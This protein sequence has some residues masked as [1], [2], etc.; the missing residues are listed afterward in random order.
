MLAS[1]RH[2]LA[3]LFVFSGRETRR[4]FWPYA[5]TVFVG[6]MIVNILLV[7]PVM[8]AAMRRTF[9]YLQQHPEGFPK[10]GPGQQPAFPPELMPDMAP[11]MG[12]MAI[13]GLLVLLLLAAAVV[14]RLHDRD[15]TGWWAALPVPFQVAGVFAAPAAYQAMVHPAA[16]PSALLVASQL[17][18]L[19]YWIAFI[20]LIVM[21][22]G[23][24]SRG[25]NRFGEA[26]PII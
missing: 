21:L 18:T 16:T 14:R 9:T 8:M 19:A 15:R 3:R 24:S 25:S 1:L 22:V 23:E 11:A 10:T 6:G 12:G 2:N 4:L 17:N 5:I 7:V 26:A 20:A 13:V